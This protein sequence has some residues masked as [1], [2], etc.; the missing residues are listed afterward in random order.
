MISVLLC[1]AVMLAL[2]SFALW[3]KNKPQLFPALDKKAESS[4]ELQQL[5]SRSEAAS[6]ES[7]ASKRAC[8]PPGAAEC[9]QPLLSSKQ[10]A[11]PRDCCGSV[12][13]SELAEDCRRLLDEIGVLQNTG[14]AC[15]MQSDCSL[16]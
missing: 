10:I 11:Y 5:A 12:I 14:E 15:V 2:V 13:N 8:C 1:M 4:A 6:A 9:K 16:R 7:A 3:A